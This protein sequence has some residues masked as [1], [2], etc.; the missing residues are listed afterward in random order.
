MTERRKPHRLSLFS[1]RLDRVAYIAYF[2]GAVVPLAALALLG[3]ALLQQSG[4]ET[5][6]VLLATFAGLG[7]LSL[8]AFFA[9]R[10]TSRQ[11]VETLDRDNR[12]L[13][14]LLLAS[15][16]LAAAEHEDEV[17]RAAVTHAARLVGSALLL[18]PADAAGRHPILAATGPAAAL[19]RQHAPADLERLA[20][21]AC[22]EERVVN[23]ALA[24]SASWQR[25]GLFA[26]ALPCRAG[27]G[28]RGA[29]VALQ[30]LAAADAERTAA[31]LGTLARMLGTALRN[32]ELRE[33]Q[34]NFYTHA[35]HLLIAALDAHIGA[36]G[37]HATAVAHHATRLGRALGLDEER[38]RRLHTA[39]LL[40]DLGMLGIARD[41]RTNQATVRLHPALGAEMLAPIR[42]WE[43]LA[44]IV[45]HH[46][47]WW[48]GGGYPDGLAGEAIP[49]EARIIGLAEAYDS[50]T[51]AASY[52]QPR[53][54]AAACEAIRAAAGTQFDPEL[55]E[56][57]IAL[58]E[59]DES[60]R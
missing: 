4:T 44:P 58:V 10:R 39:A 60:G 46:H 53:S 26:T 56:R 7:I 42:L 27:D 35:T 21:A 22:E 25:G 52:Q 3:R 47:E 19:A 41:Q 8:A 49:L 50:M 6:P 38:L 11:A 45:R 31:F 28:P 16:D 33:T 59:K 24:G 43:E 57:L 34:R 54:P 51:N 29:L 15:R 1:Q 18:G 32:A 48:N 37:A 17:H 14:T 5:R 40:H 36:Q 55:A 2:L 13:A 12:Q 30:P 20:Q 23:E 9:L